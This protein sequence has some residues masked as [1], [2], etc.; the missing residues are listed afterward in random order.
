MK[1]SDNRH[2]FVNLQ[3]RSWTQAYSRLLLI[4]HMNPLTNLHSMKLPLYQIDAFTD[5]LF[6]GNPACVVPLPRWLPEAV[7]CNIAK[8]NGVAET[9]FFIQNAGKIH[10]RW[11]TPEI[12]MDLCG[13]ATLATAHA[14]R[15]IMQR[16]EAVYYFETPSGR[17][18]VTIEQDLYLLDFPSRPPEPATLPANIQQALNLAPTKV[19]N[20]KVGL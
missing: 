8:E 3:L 13:H 2:N 7:L 6:Q 12:E 14:L 9:A 19:L 10:L 18:S 15:T 17:L 5:Q 1:Y 4:F 20:T 16:D 11:F